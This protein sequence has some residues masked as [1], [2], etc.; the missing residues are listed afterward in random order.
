MGGR[1]ETSGRNPGPQLPKL[2][3]AGLSRKRRKT[4]WNKAFFSPILFPFLFIR[5]KAQLVGTL[6]WNNGVGAAVC[7]ARQPK[8]ILQVDVHPAPD[9]SL[10]L[11]TLM[12][13][14]GELC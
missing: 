13:T 9:K 8:S 10:S 14:S 4:I 11:F 1:D 6:H 7:D 2:L 5:P 12:I 3:G